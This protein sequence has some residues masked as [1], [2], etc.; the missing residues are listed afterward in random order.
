MV[1]YA[2]FARLKPTRQRKR[3]REIPGNRTNTGPARINN[4]DLVRPA[5]GADNI[6][7]I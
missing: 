6:R 1:K 2:L 5:T 4:A 3:C 7:H